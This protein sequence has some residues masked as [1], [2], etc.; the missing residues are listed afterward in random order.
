MAKMGLLLLWLGAAVLVGTAAAAGQEVE[1]KLS[2][3]CEKGP[4][5]CDVCDEN[6]KQ[7][8]T[9]SSICPILRMY[10]LWR[11]ATELL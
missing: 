10:I 5:L 1:R 4:C 9:P 7:Q 11:G 3:G 8:C 6:C 2:Y